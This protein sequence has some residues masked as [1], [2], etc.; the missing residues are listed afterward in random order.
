[1]APVHGPM[2]DVGQR[3][4][5]D[6]NEPNGAASPFPEASTSVASTPSANMPAD[7]H[8]AQTRQK[9][10]LPTRSRRGG[11]GV[12]SCDADIMILE[13]LKRKRASTVHATCEHR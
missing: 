12:G 9:R 10:V 13:T 3:P 8:G 11:P 2:G 1:M 6:S 4:S 7:K 5:D